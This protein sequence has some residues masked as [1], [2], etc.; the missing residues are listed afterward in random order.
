MLSTPFWFDQ[1]QCKAEEISP[2]YYRITG[3]NLPETFL[4]IR[5]AENGN[6]QAYLRFARDGEDAAVTAAD[7]VREYDA[8]EAAFEL[9]RA[10]VIL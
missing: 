2:V 8:W 10:K 5:R 4:G 9:Y 6:F 7:F 3:P 1:R